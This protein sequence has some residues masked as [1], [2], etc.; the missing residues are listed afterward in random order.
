MEIKNIAVIG[1][2]IMGCDVALDLSC[3]DYNII[4][5][6]VCSETLEKAKKRIKSELRISKMMKPSIKHI[7]EEI[8]F[9]RISFATDYRGFDS[10]DLV[11]ENVTEDWNIKEKVYGE[12]SEVCKK[13]TYYAINTSCIPITK[14]SALLPDPA[15]VMGVHFMNPVPLKKLVETIRGYHTSKDTENTIVEFLKSIGKN[16]VVVEDFPGFVANRLSHLFMNE[17]AF[18]VQDKVAEPKEI[19]AIFVQGY[20]HKMGPLETADLIGL[21]TVVNSLDVLYQEY[22]DP[23][24]RCCP[25]LKKMVQAGLKGRKSGK[26]FY[27]YND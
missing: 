7:T 1:A 2:G 26:G 21:D 23:K 24:F 6:D 22:Q 3:Y 19:D 17:A 12:L 14:V 10:V 15:K 11:V 25:L 16:P 9:S 18:L 4:L 27:T 8:V 13:D 20:G 5:K